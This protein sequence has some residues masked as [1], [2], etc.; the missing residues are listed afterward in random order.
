LVRRALFAATIALAA[1]PAV[2]NAETELNIIPHGQQE[3]GASWA[4]APGMLPANAQALMYDRLTPLG[5][6]VTDATLAPSPSPSEAPAAS[7][8]SSAAPATPA[9]SAAPSA[10]SDS[11]NNTLLIGVALVLVIG[12]V[13]ATLVV[14]RR[15][16]A[17]A[18]DD[19]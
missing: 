4:S 6:N 7:D 18:G 15:R 10:A 19:E 12:A 11:S 14:S 16:A 1:A 9:P 17:S 8:G 3:P 13:V 2:A 5:R